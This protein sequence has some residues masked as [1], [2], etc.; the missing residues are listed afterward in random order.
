MFSLEQAI[1]EWR[2]QMLAAGIKTPVPLDELESHLREDMEQQMRS[3]LSAPQAFEVAVQR[4]GQADALKAEFKKAGGTKQTREQKLARLVLCLAGL[5]YCWLL[6]MGK[7][8]L[9]KA[10]MSLTARLLGLAAV[11]V[12]VTAVF[13]GQYAYRFLPA[14]PDKRVR[15]A[16]Q[17]VCFLPAV[18]WLPVYAYVVLPRWDFDGFNIGPLIAATLWTLAALPVAVSLWKG[19][20]EAASR[21]TAMAAS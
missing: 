8:G 9:L 17:I 10:E 14:L 2:R 18:V 5:S 13:S 4:I 16:I 1:A 12:S 20:D 15:T 21:Q 19:L 3:G 11:A 6:L 7:Y